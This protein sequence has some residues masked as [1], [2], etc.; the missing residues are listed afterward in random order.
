MQ[1]QGAVKLP[2]VDKFMLVKT[3][4]I[5]VLFKNAYDKAVGTPALS[6][7]KDLHI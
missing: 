1:S 7:G 3:F 5:F 4:I 6:S 2:D